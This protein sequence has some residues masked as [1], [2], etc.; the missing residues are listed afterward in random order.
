MDPSTTRVATPSTTPVD[1]PI[2]SRDDDGLSRAQPLPAPLAV[3]PCHARALPR[4]RRRL[5]LAAL[6]FG[7]GT[8]G[9]DAEISAGEY[10]RL[11]EP[12]GRIARNLIIIAI[13][14]GTLT[15]GLGAAAIHRRAARP[16]LVL[17]A[18]L[19]VAGATSLAGDRL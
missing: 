11:Y 1:R 19:T 15:V 5:A 14:G 10:A 12:G 16:V 7:L 8:S 18:L 6:R 13:A 2:K 9:E 17:R 3:R 4:L